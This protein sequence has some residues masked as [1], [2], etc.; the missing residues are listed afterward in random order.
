MIAIRNHIFIVL[1]LRKTILSYAGFSSLDII[2]TPLSWSFPWVLNLKHGVW[3][4]RSASSVMFYMHLETRFSLTI[5]K[6]NRKKNEESVARCIK[7]KERSYWQRRKCVIISEYS[8]KGTKKITNKTKYILCILY[9]SFSK[10]LVQISSF[11]L[12]ILWGRRN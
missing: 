12:S 5:W 6:R 11:G 4:W 2:I 7:F 10:P 9:H 8:F 1:V 3:L